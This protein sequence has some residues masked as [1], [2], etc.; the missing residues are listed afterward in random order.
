MDLNKKSGYKIRFFKE[1]SQNS[2]L[3]ALYW[4]I[5]PFVELS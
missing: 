5:K 1:Y 3:Q 2:Y 4:L